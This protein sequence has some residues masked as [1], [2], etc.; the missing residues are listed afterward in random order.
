MLILRSTSGAELRNNW[1]WVEKG[2]QTI[3]RK[4][5]SDFIAADVYSQLM[6]ETLVFILDR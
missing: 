4:T 3:I 5:G 1:G 6:Y 2:L